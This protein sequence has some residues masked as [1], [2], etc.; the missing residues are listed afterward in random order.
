MGDDLSP[1]ERQSQLSG[2]D[3][4]AAQG[5]EEDEGGS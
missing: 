3:E 2:A 1:G 4:P 5:V